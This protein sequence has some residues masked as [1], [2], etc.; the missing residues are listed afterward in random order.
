MSDNFVLI[1]PYKKNLSS[2]VVPGRL[3]KNRRSKNPPS[4]G[5]QRIVYI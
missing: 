2:G 5:A 1:L 3:W 4:E